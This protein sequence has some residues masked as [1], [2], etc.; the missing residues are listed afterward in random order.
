MALEIVQILASGTFGHVAVVRDTQD[1]RLMAAK[2]L[3]REHLENPKIVRRMMDEAALLRRLDHPNIVRVEEVRELEGRPVMLLEWV[4]GA[5]LDEIVVA[6]P[7]GI[8]IADACAIVMIAS[9]ALF[10]AWYTTEPTTGGP[11]HVIHRDIKPSNILLADDGEVK[12]LDFGI[13]RGQFEGRQSETVSVVLGAHGY[14]APERLDGAEDT[15]YGDVYA[16]GCVLYE[17]LTSQRIRLSLHPRAHTERLQKGIMHI[18]PP[19]V[20][21][22]TVSDLARLVQRM[23]AYDPDDRPDHG[24]VVETLHVIATEAG[25]QPDLPRLARKAVL[26][27][28]ASRSLDSPVRHPAW[29]ELRFLETHTGG[30]P[31][32]AP[33]RE[34]DLRLARFLMQDDWHERSEQLRRTLA[35]DPSWTARPLLDALTRLEG[36]S[37]WS[38]LVGPQG[39]TRAQIVALLDLLRSR[40]DQEVLERVRPYLRHRDPELVLLARQITEDHSR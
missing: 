14:L 23:C 15:P 8:P 20:G 3:K 37:F 7:Q 30:T 36:G 1:G 28:L 32:G 11:L 24:E 38:R 9:D 16:M 25:F 17:L 27:L 29:Q 18:R 2:V 19:G 4:R 40:P 34:S 26:P 39:Q 22:R 12:L 33:T 35:A 21:A 31:A 5:S 13:A 10:A 6:S